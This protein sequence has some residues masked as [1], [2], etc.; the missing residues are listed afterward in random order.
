MADSRARRADEADHRARIA[1]Q[2]AQRDRAEAQVRQ[3]KAALHERGMADDELVG[4]NERERFAGTSAVPDEQGAA[5]AG[6]PPEG[7]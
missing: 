5:E 2:E 7:T 3:E 1:E 4:D 6:P